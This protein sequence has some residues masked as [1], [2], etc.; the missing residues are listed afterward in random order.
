MKNFKTVRNHF[1]HVLGCLGPQIERMGAHS[2]PSNGLN[3]ENGACGQKFV[4]ENVSRKCKKVCCSK[5]IL[6]FFGGYGKPGKSVKVFF[7]HHTITHIICLSDQRIPKNHQ[8]I[9]RARWII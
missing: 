6:T 5:I 4:P 3:Y 2:S 1:R 7:R 9:H 8:I